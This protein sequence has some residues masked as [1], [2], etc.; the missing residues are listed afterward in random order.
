MINHHMTCLTSCN[1][2]L[3]SLTL[4]L[5]PW[6]PAV[7]ML[8][9][10]IAVY[11]IRQNSTARGLR[12]WVPLPTIVQ[13]FVNNSSKSESTIKAY[14]TDHASASHYRRA[15]P[16]ELDWLKRKKAVSP[17]ST[18]V[19]LVSMQRCLAVGRGLGVPEELLTELAELPMAV[20]L[21]TTAQAAA[22][23]VP[24]PTPVTAST[25]QALSQT[26]STTAAAIQAM[27]PA[28]LPPC[29]LSQAEL[30]VWHYGLT[31]QPI[32]Q[33]PV[34][35]H[36]RAALEGL[37]QWSRDFVRMD[38]PMDVDWLAFSSWKGNQ[39]EML[40]FLGF[41]CK[42]KG[43][44]QPTLQHYLNGFLVADFIS[45]LKAREVDP[46][47]L[48]DH[49]HQAE[50]V[51]VYLAS[52]NQISHADLQLYSPYRG[53]LANMAHQLKKN[54]Q[55]APKP[56]LEELMQQGTYMQA[57][58]LLVC[59]HKVG[60]RA[61]ARKGEVGDS[62]EAAKENM[63]AAYGMSFFGY[64]P[65]LRPSVVHSLQDPDYSGPCL[66]PDCQHPNKCKG[67]RVEIEDWDST[68]DS[69]MDSSSTSSLD[70]TITIF[71]PHHK[72]SKWWK[73]NKTIVCKLPPILARLYL[74]HYLEGRGMLLS[75]CSSDPSNYFF[76]QVLK[77]EQL[78]ESQASQIF[79]SVVLPHTHHFGPQ[80]ARAIFVTAARGGQLGS[81]DV[82]AAAAIM[83]NSYRMW[84]DVYDREVV[85]RGAADNVAALA[86]WR[87]RVLSAAGVGVTTGVGPDAAAG[88]AGAGAA[89]RVGAGA[90]A[91]VGAGAAPRGVASA[92]R[93]GVGAGVG[94]AAGVGVDVAA[95][96]GGATS[97]ELCIDLTQDTDS[98]SMDTSSDSD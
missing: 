59:L 5:L 13:L 90:A 66:H 68:S 77:G 72:A 20:P 8:A 14:F 80:R 74:T 95:G 32:A 83:G 98:D 40:R 37:R 18:M 79:A 50:R 21:T 26:V 70:P 63:Y 73:K 23:A 58:E 10:G 71:A 67:N 11:V 15:E 19:N 30:E 56:S 85:A 61:T 81:V 9:G 35:N 48:A 7:V 87:S 47:Q 57:D 4:L 24:T 82:Q 31:T 42:H 16:A 38:R 46:N 36:I 86:K 89:A 28:R 62:W 17:R 76:V 91:G 29:T 69:S 49:V 64:V 65:P 22:P 93:V 27:C 54:L 84:E 53:W 96:V 12:E 45:F 6:C 44:Q 34:L 52:T 75:N 2:N 43:V 51:V 55:S 3:V 1:S 78:L 88:A 39:G 25:A 33:G 94:V 97:K 41:I 92:P 60:E